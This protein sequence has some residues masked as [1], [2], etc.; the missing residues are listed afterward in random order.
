MHR[1]SLIVPFGS[2]GMLADEELL[3]YRRVLDEQDNRYPVEII[4]AGGVDSQQGERWDDSLVVVAANGE[5]PVGALRAGIEA[6]SGEM[7]V[8]LDPRRLYPPEALVQVVE[9]LNASGSDLV[10]A[11]PQAQAGR[12]LR[13]TLTRKCLGLAGQLSLGTSDAFSGLMAFRRSHLSS[14]PTVHQPRGSRLVLDLLAWPCKTHVDVAVP[15][16]ADDRPTLGPPGSTISA[17]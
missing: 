5:G 15:T 4:L 13:S 10:I 8:V 6:A 7:V 3:A 2:A 14:F 16:A 11:V 1:I 17:S 9:A 12:S